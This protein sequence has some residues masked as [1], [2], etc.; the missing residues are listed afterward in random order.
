MGVSCMYTLAPRQGQQQ[1]VPS[2]PI[3]ISSHAA[4][5]R[6]PDP[7]RCFGGRTDPTRLQSFGSACVDIS[8]VARLLEMK[9]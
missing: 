2:I 3:T 4:S 8:A 9:C 5:P 6:D 1:G 7:R